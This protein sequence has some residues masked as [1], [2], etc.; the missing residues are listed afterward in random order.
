MKKVY[1]TV[2]ISLMLHLVKAALPELGWGPQIASGLELYVATTGVDTNDG[3]KDKPYKTILKAQ[4]VIRSMKTANTIPAGGVTVWI[5]GGRYQIAPLSFT[6]ADN[7]TAD[8]P[9]I[10]RAYTGESVSLFTGK[11]IAPSNWKPLNAAA[12]LRVNPRVNPD[13]LR[14]ID[15]AAMGVLSTTIFPNSFIT[16]W[17]LFDFMVNNQRQP[18]SQWPNPDENIRNLNNPG[19][20]T[21]NGSADAQS[22]YYGRGGKPM[23]DITTNELDLDGTNRAQ[24]WKTSMAAGHNLWLKGFW[25][26]PWSPVI[27]K[28]S[29]IN[30]N[31][32]SIKL[33]VNNYGGM[34]S[35]Y[36]TNADAAGTYRYGNGKERWCLI[37]YLDEIDQPGEWAYDFMD[38]KVYYY[39]ATDLS[40]MEA[41]FADNSTSVIT[42]NTVSWVKFIALTIEGGQGDGFA[43]N[44]CS[45]LFV[46]G[47]TIRNVGGNGISD[48]G[49]S[50]NTYQGNNIY[51]TGTQGINLASCGNRQTLT[52][53]NIS[54]TNNH[55]HHTGKLTSA[56]AIKIDQCVGLLVAHNLI[57]DIPSGGITTYL[58]N[59]SVF[60]YNEIHNIAQTESDNGAFYCYGAWTTY[61]NEIRYN[62]VHHTSRT[63]GF[64]PDDG[65]SGYNFFSN[66]LQNCLNP[67]LTGGGHHVIGRNCLIVDGLKVSSIDDRGI[68]RFYFVSAPNYGGKVKALNPK[69]EPWL[70]YGK[71]LIA[72]YGYAANDSLWGCTLDS[73]WHP[74]YPNGSKFINN[75]E[76][77]SKGFTKPTHGTVTLSGNV[78]LTAVADAGFYD[79]ANMDLR[80]NNATILG[81][82]PELNTVFPLMGLALDDYRVR[83]VS[84]AEVGGLVNRGAAGDPWDQDPVHP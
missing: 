19:W 63:C 78:A 45:N 69:A 71:S 16:G 68:S 64:G 23:D 21:C 6:A 83:L 58:T 41:Y 32:N 67:M 75:V 3:T 73:L 15:V 2:F 43:F 14:E 18:I 62:F 35:K 13:S 72:K 56:F 70:S 29:D 55:I 38:K 47:C 79:Y 10:Y 81:K 40:K 17:S 36:S 42:C 52:S 37:N 51:E 1:L 11:Q 28:V 46:G 74:E 24:R 12:R 66:V 31:A 7:G 27:V 60:E 77:N 9:I 8:K 39:P 65:T 20:T 80:S 22:F 26:V 49:G 50:N 4:T 59:N 25:R 5:R 76:V 44:N 34:G 84:R 57:H 82:F 61:G 53:S 54:V 30:T 33:I 48:T